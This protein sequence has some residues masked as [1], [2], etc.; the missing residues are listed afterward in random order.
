VLVF[1]LWLYEG[2]GV[3]LKVVRQTQLGIGA[4]QPLKSG[5][6]AIRKEATPED[7]FA[8]IYA[9]LYSPMYRK[10]YA[11]F[12][13]T[14]FPRIPLPKDMKQFE[15]LADLGQKLINL[16]LLR[17]VPKPSAK[18]HGTGPDKVEKRDYRAKEKQL[19]FNNAQYIEP[20]E[21]EVWQ[22]QIGGYQVLDKWLKDRVDRSLSDSEKEHY[23]KII[24][25]ISETFRLQKDIDANVDF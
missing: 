13:K 19:W 17:H 25:A 2:G 15:V 24:G 9:V 12:L 18:F 7:I 1:P 11:E 3:E 10:K 6:S 16:H 20:I 5:E 4:Q 14:D 21:S 23:L 8:Y 22:Y